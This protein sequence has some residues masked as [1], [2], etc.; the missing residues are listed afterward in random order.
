MIRK[1]A[2]MAAAAAIAAPHAAIAQSNAERDAARV[3][4]RQADANN[5]RVLSRRE[6]RAFINANADDGIG[7]APMVRRLGAYDTAFE[8]VDRNGNGVV[9]PAELAAAGSD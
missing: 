6:F 8:R 4:F 9:T 2:V 7:R 3:N 1:I 5:D